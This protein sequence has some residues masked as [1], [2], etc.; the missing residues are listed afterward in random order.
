MFLALSQSGRVAGDAEVRYTS[1]LHGYPVELYGDR[2]CM[3]VCTNSGIASQ[4]NGWRPERCIQDQSV[5][6][7]CHKGRCSYRITSQ[8]R[9]YIYFRLIVRFLWIW[10]NKSLRLPPTLICYNF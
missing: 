1:W 6:V 2:E 9:P 4:T 7:I 8:N 5:G 10:Y 3:S